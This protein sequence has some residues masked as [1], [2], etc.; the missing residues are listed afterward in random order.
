MDVND[1]LLTTLKGLKHDPTLAVALYRKLF[2]A[3]F[4]A[5]I[6]KPFQALESSNFL[7]Y[8]AGE[9]MRELPIFTHPKRHLLM[10]ISSQIE[11]SV[12]ID[13]HG[14]SLWPRMLDIVVQGNVK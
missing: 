2:S 1:E 10:D 9:E 5:I 13:V 4:W 8:P 11:D 3:R 12:V 7:T 6:Q 14:R